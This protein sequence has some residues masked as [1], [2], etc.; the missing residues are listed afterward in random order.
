MDHQTAM[1]IMYPYKTY[2]EYAKAKFNS[3]IKI[4]DGFM[5]Q[6]K[7]YKAADAYELASIY[8]LKNARAYGRRGL[9]L[10]A[11][12]EY[13]TCVEYMEMALSRSPQYAKEKIDLKTFIGQ[14]V[15]DKRFAN[16]LK[17]YESNQS[18]SFM[19]LASYIYYQLG[20]LEQAARSVDL[21]A[22][23]MAGFASV[24]AMRSAIESAQS[25]E[26]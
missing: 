8:D 23:K 25:R 10:F 1:G 4:G 19:L 6:G 11:A 15:V 5:K 9:A 3:Y 21:A 17:W 2:K 16:I 14:E 26:R 18:P 20:D 7:F 24:D 22:E 12:G 13:L